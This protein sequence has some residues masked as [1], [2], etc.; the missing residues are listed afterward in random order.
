MT[1]QAF[2]ERCSG[3]PGEEIILKGVT[4]LRADVESVESL[5]V[6]I[7]RPRLESLG[8]RLPASA[9]NPDADRALYR[10]LSEIHGDGA[11]SQFN[12]WIRRLV[13][14]ERALA[15]RVSANVTHV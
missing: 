7:G 8:V 3:L 15:Q 5:L 9:T 10:R 14:F 13:S 1:E 12:S 2:Q 11:H 4:D 6:Q